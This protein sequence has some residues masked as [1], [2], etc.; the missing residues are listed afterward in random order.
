[1]P[2]ALFVALLIGWAG[3]LVA[4]VGALPD[5][6]ASHFAWGGQADAWMTRDGY[7]TWMLAFGVVFPVLVTAIVALLPRGWPGLAFVNLPNRDYWFAPERRADS[8]GY[9]GRHACWLGCL[10]VLMTAGVHALILRAHEATPPTLPL[11]PFVSL[12]IG[13]LIG[14]GVWIVVLYRRFHR[15]A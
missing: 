9:L 11:A 13:F 4:T 8:L 3:F 1:M 2:C 14:V 7:L 6:V 15:P 10:I 12:L 5:H